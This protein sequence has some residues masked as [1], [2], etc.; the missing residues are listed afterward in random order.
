MTV[1]FARSKYA[2]IFVLLKREFQTFLTKYT[3]V[4]HNTKSNSRY[5]IVHFFMDISSGI[6]SE[7]GLR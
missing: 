6:D 1:S 3:Y 7:N 5:C 4:V 2:E